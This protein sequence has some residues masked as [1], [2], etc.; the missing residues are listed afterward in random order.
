M[1]WHVDE[2]AAMRYASA[3]TDPATAAAIEAHVIA[4]AECQS[5]VG[6]TA[7][8][9]LLASIW[10]DIDD[11][12]DQPH[13]GPVERMLRWFGCSD[14]VSRIVAATTHAHL[15]FLFVVAASI[16]LAMLA[17]GPANDVD[18]AFGAFL[19]VAPLGPMAATVGAFGRRTDPTYALSHTM[20]VSAFRIILV[21]TIA[22]VI[23]ATALTLLATPWLLDRGWL[24]AA[25]LL[26]S[27]AL[28]SIVL[29]LSSWID[30]EL[31]A[32][33]VALAWLTLPFWLRFGGAGLTDA[34][35]GPI[36]PVST[37]ALVCAVG[38]VLLRRT[39]FEYGRF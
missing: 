1:S 36:Q 13:L 6:R 7:D 32:L 27:L 20:P 18:A 29:A 14:T 2:M 8:T 3:S 33:I 26:P 10:N 17:A 16:A 22:A 24:A 15:S 11:I 12:I 21:R 39:N 9:E 38:L 31:A 35:A 28:A 25:W 19:L 34:F 37:A 23:P 4:C 5:V 30:I